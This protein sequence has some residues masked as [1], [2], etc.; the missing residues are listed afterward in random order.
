MSNKTINLDNVKI[1]QKTLPLSIMTGFVEAVVDSCVD[2]TTG[3]YLPQS[4]D[5]AIKLNTVLYYSDCSLPEKLDE[6]YRI[7]LESDLYDFITDNINKTQYREM[8]RAIDRKIKFKLD[9]ISYSL[10]TPAKQIIDKINNLI[11]ENQKTFETINKTDINEL[12]KSINDISNRN[13]KD[14]AVTIS[15]EPES[16]THTD[17]SDDKSKIISLTQSDEDGF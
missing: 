1:T 13:D 11:S 17:I 4:Y 9:C 7:L 5:L 6:Q 14:I 15:Q 10:T 12:I 16:N 2:E 8:L 3:E